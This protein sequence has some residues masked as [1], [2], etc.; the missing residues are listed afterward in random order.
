M[1][2]RFKNLKRGNLVLIKPISDEEIKTTLFDMDIL[3]TL[4]SD[5]FHALSFKV[6]GIKLVL[7]FTLG[8]RRFL[9]GRVLI[10]I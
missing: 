2:V 6:S 3:K 8:L 9:N 4:G 5:G 10:R 1:L 7:Q